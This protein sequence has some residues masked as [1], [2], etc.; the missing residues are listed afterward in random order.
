MIPIIEQSTNDGNTADGINNWGQYRKHLDANKKQSSAMS[1]LA[2]NSY[3]V[4]AAIIN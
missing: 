4:D 2:V 3:K 1:G